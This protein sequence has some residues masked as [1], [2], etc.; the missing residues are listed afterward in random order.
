MADE[1]IQNAERLRQN[2]ATRAANFSA[3][4][5]SVEGTR[6]GAAGTFVAGAKVFDTVS[7]L[8]G[9]VEGAPLLAGSRVVDVQIRLSNGE[10]V[11]RRPELLIV[12]PV[13]PAPSSTT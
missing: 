6:A 12:R 1:L 4:A 10:R 11:M 7:G 5:G 8:D 9:V 3:T 2:R 13:P